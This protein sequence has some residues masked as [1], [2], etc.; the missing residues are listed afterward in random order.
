MPAWG[1]VVFLSSRAFWNMTV[2]PSADA[3]FFTS[4]SPNLGSG[5]PLSCTGSHVNRNAHNGFCLCWAYRRHRRE[6]ASSR[7]RRT[8][9][10]AGRRGR[11]R[12]GAK[13]RREAVARREG[14]LALYEAEGRRARRSFPP[15]RKGSR[16]TARTRVRPRCMDGATKAPPV[17]LSRVSLL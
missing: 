14:L 5:R 3:G 10:P 7:G 6:R 11:E 8:R 16:L 17:E 2:K 13:N 1:A 9:H 4:Q 15:A 12:S